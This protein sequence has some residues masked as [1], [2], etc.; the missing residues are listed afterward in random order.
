M[1]GSTPH[2][3]VLVR[4]EHHHAFRFSAVTVMCSDQA[5]P[6]FVDEELPRLLEHSDAIVHAE[7]LRQG[8]EDCHVGGR[9][10]VAR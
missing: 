3:G 10:V 6:K 1:L 5:F 9:V 7:V 8:E 4:D 2:L